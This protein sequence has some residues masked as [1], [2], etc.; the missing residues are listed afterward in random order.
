V[1]SGCDILTNTAD[2]IAPEILRG[3]WG[4]GTLSLDP[5]SVYEYYAIGNENIIHKEI[6][7]GVTIVDQVLW[8]SKVFEEEGGYYFNFKNYT[9]GIKVTIINEYTIEILGDMYTKG[10]DETPPSEVSDVVYYIDTENGKNPRYMFSWTNPTDTDLRYIKVT[11]MFY[12]SWHES[13]T[14]KSVWYY[15][16]QNTYDISYDDY[17]LSPVSV[18]I[19]TADK[20]DNIS[21]G[22]KFDLEY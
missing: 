3:T 19:Q 5:Y 21:T 15:Y 9:Y 10:G 6:D 1:L 22:I 8:I 4:R 12:N 13:Y 7:G 20:S 18:L 11:T 16:G 17:S 14:T 2:N